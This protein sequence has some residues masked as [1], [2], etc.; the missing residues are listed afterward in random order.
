[1]NLLASRRGNRPCAL[2]LECSVC[3][4][5]VPT[6]KRP[7]S[8]P[9]QM[10][11]PL[12]GA[13][14]RALVSDDIQHLQPFSQAPCYLPAP[15]LLMMYILH[16]LIHTTRLYFHRCLYSG[17]LPSTVWPSNYPAR[18]LSL[19]LSPSLPPSRPLPREV[20]FSLILVFNCWVRDWSVPGRAVGPYRALNL[21][22]F[23][24]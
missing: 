2:L 8:I 6:H 11:G 14:W 12:I 13:A 22:F 18:S 24:A 17:F 19:S 1:M 10:K 5:M 23:R 15:L 9:D 7:G 20:R 16:H 4:G 3:S 21:P